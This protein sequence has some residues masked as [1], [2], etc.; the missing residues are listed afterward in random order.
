[1]RIAWLNAN[2]GFV[3]D[4]TFKLK[5]VTLYIL[6]AML[7]YSFMAGF[8][9]GT[10]LASWIDW[11]A[12]KSAGVVSLFGALAQDAAPRSF[13][14]TIVFWR[15]TDR[16]PGC[17]AFNRR[18]GDRYDLNRISNINEV[19]TLSSDQ[20]QQL[21]YRIYKKHASD[22]TV[23]QSSFR[24]VAWRDT[25]STFFLLALLTLPVGLIF[26]EGF[27]PS[28]LLKLTAFAASSY[29]LTTIAARQAANSL[30]GQ[31]LSCETAEQVHDIDI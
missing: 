5:I 15:L 29:L 17:R 20:Q 11:K 16:L 10:D 1:M 30:V 9:F 22:D 18:C 21:F 3:V 13:K 26:T 2:R 25:A 4:K 24:Y 27:S 6:P 14:E 19:E 28:I 23:A 31:V 7:A 8:L 12:L